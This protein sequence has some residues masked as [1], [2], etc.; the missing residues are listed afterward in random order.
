MYRL[1]VI[2]KDGSSH[3]GKYYNLK[4][5]FSALE[6]FGAEIRSI[7]LVSCGD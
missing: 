2:F 7:M 5:V 1:S 4:N 3:Y 6:S